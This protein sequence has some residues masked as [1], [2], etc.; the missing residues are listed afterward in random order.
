VS[1]DARIA[2]LEALLAQIKKRSAEPRTRAASPT[3]PEPAPVPVPVP[4]IATP[5]P[6]PIPS[7]IPLPVPA[8][9]PPAFLPTAAPPAPLLEA[10]DTLA[11]IPHE[12]EHDAT[13][14]ERP[15][16][17]PAPRP[18]E[19]SRVRAIDTAFGEPPPMELIELEIEEPSVPPPPM[20]EA[21]R[22]VSETEIFESRS[23][24]VTA[25]P[26]ALPEAP[27][28]DESLR[29]TPAPEPP[30]SEPTLP[31]GDARA[32]S[33]ASLDE[34]E[35][36]EAAPSSSRRPISVEEKLKQLAEDDGVHVPPPES[37][38]QP[39][40]PP[41]PLAFAPDETGVRRSDDLLQ[42]TRIAPDAARPTPI[43]GNALDAAASE[44]VA[45][46][47]GKPPSPRPAT[48]GDLI[49]QALKL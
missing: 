10:R 42:P 6:P 18:P 40:V 17:A 5:I 13:I 44:S 36:E 20:P 11:P 49:D 39:A 33:A 3:A 46:F 37:G 27:D 35:E 38:R 48:F 31:L 9:L 23:R 1:P 45:A 25:A 12:A 15:A 32:A 21:D 4:E 26:V 8:E 30:P 47:V 34:I 43:S 16:A 14:P 24:L 19:P 41:I 22:R 29:Q 7:A 2:K 28:D